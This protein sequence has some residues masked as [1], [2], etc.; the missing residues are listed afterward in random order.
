MRLSRSLGAALA[1]IAALTLMAGCASTAD[2][3][4][5]DPAT[6]DPAPS[7]SGAPAE[8]AETES[9]RPDLSTA[10]LTTEDLAD[11]TAEYG[12]FEESQPERASADSMVEGDPLCADYLGDDYGAESVADAETMFYTEFEA[13]AGDDPAQLAVYSTV[14]EFDTADDAIEEL[15]ALREIFA[16]CEA[17]TLDLDG[18]EVSM[19]VLNTGDANELYDTGEEGVTVAM[20]QDVGGN[21]VGEYGYVFTRIENYIVFSGAFKGGLTMPIDSELMAPITESAAERVRD[22]IDAA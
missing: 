13:D 3:D 6:S 2:P 18:T 11:L 9:E 17:Y 16:A 22:Y 7:T 1:S 12:D 8:A 14:T 19:Q 10:L 5:S 20:S 21:L 4:P 15:D